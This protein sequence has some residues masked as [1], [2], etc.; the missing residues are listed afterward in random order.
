MTPRL[1]PLSLP[2]VLVACSH[3]PPPRAVPTHDATATPPGWFPETPWTAQGVEGR[4]YLEGKVVFESGQARL[5]PESERVLNDL[6]AYLVAN[7][8]ITRVRI[9]GHTDL[10]ASEERNQKLSERRAL[11]VADWL[12]DHGID[13]DRLLAV[14][15]GELRPRWPATSANA[16]QENRRVEFHVAEVNGNRF[17]GEDPTSG[18][19]VLYV[20]SK[21]ER[22]AEKRKAPPPDFKVPEVK[23]ERDIIKAVEDKKQRDLLEEPEAPATPPSTLPKK[24]DGSATP[25]Q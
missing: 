23:A 12:V 2:L 11:A 3:V 6:L 7:P 10:R 17:Q 22:E 16:M 8:D 5:R 19:L 20:K 14:A 15:F 18:G 13:H 25:A 21:E 1:S 24:G 9:E 4:V